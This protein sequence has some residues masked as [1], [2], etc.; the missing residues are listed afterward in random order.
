MIGIYVKELIP[1]YSELLKTANTKTP[2][3]RAT[4][5]RALLA[6][7]QVKPNLPWNT[8][9]IREILIHRL[10]L[11]TSHGEIDTPFTPGTPT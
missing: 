9:E 1:M 4:M 11:K 2:C 7:A 3:E 5:S 6:C 8:V 10:L